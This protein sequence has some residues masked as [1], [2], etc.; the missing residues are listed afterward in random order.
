MR[1]VQRKR[2]SGLYKLRG[3]YLIRP[4]FFRRCSGGGIGR[5]TRL[6]GVCRKAWGFE[7]PPEHHSVRGV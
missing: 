7:S 1:K 4:S 2:I 5:H 3:I 6:R